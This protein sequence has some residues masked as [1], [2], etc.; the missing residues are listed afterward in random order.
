MAKWA[1]KDDNNNIVELIDFDPT[2]KFHP[3]IVWHEV[4][5]SATVADATAP[6]TLDEDPEPQGPEL[7]AEE[8]AAKAEAEAAANAALGL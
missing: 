6:V 8:L 7:T 3:D 5:D 1:R 2:G 4:A